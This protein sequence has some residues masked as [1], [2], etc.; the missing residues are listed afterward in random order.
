MRFEGMSPRA[1]SE[2]LGMRLKRARLNSNL[3]QVEVAHKSGVSRKTVV[4]AEKGQ[5]SLE[6]LVAIL[7][8]LNL[9]K[10]LDN[11]LPEQDVSPVQLMKLR[12]NKRQRASGKRAVKK[13]ARVAEW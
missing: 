11:F 9:A 5:V 6:N 2:E 13:S 7:S 3:T 10:Q 4:N 12:R 8:A 1:M